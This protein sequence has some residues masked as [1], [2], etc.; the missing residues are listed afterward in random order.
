MRDLVEGVPV[1]PLNFRDGDFW[2]DVADEFNAVSA[3]LQRLEA[4]LA[5][6]R[7]ETPFEGVYPVATVVR[8]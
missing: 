6:V 3:K 7:G 8:G 4:E 5:E 1:P 2:A